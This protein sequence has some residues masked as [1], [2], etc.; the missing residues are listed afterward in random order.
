MT[1]HERESP[2]TVHIFRLGTTKL[3]INECFWGEVYV[4]KTLDS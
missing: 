3:K 4:G 2:S 1:K